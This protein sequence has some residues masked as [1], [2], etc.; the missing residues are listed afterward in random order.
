VS[1]LFQRCPELPEQRV[2][3]T[4]PASEKLPQIIR[5]A[6]D[7]FPGHFDREISTGLAQ[8]SRGD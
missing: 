6:F 7:Q 3:L 5:G 2:R 4:P 1:R 8:G